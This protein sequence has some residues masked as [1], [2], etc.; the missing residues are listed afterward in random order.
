MD[1]QIGEAFLKIPKISSFEPGSEIHCIF[2]Q[3]NLKYKSPKKN[4]KCNKKIYRSFIII[5][6]LFNSGKFVFTIVGNS[7]L[8]GVK[9]YV[10]HITKPVDLSWQSKM[11]SMVKVAT[12][13]LDTYDYASAL[14][15]VEKRFWDFCDNYLEIVKKRAYSP[16]DTSAVA[17][18]MLTIDTFL[19]AFAPFCPFIA[20]ELYQC[21][22]WNDAEKSLH[23]QADRKSVV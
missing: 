6:K 7:K 13:Y 23:N 17:S 3:H 22:P 15:V 8:N 11:A 18:L 21:R 5:N 19:K 12:D 1:E 16:E 14:D 20:E 9:D 4:W 10:S 2:D